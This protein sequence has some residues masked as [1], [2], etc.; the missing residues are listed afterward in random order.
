MDNGTRKRMREMVSGLRQALEAELGSGVWSAAMRLAFAACARA[1]GI[2]GEL[3]EFFGHVEGRLPAAAAAAGSA[4]LAGNGDLLAAPAALGWLHQFWHDGERASITA[5]GRADQYAKIAAGSLATATQVYSEEYMVDFLLANSLG[6]LWLDMYPASRLATKWPL[7]VRGPERSRPYPQHDAGLITV[8][9]PACGAGN[10]LL[11]AFDMLFDIYAEAGERDPGAAC[12]AILTNSLFGLDIDGRAVAV[13]RAALWLQA[14]AKAPGLAAAAG[15]ALVKNIVAVNGGQAAREMGSLLAAREVSG[16]AAGLLARRYAVVATNPPYLDKRDYSPEARGYLRRH[17]PAGAGNVYAAFILRCLGM[18]D[19]FVGMVTPQTF[20]FIRS[21]A[22]LRGEIFRR[23]GI[24][25]LAHL[26]LGAFSGPVVD[27]A[28]FV[29]DRKAE[30]RDGPGVYFKLLDEQL[31]E[32]ALRFAVA[33]HN[34]GA[35]GPGV[36]IRTTGQATALPGRPVAYWLGDGLR[37]VLEGSRPL[38]D[39]ADVVLGMK[40]SDNRRFVRYWWEVAGDD[41]QPLPGWAPYEKEASGYRYGRLPAHC[42]RW[43]EAAQSH[44][45][46]H[47]SAQLPNRRYWF[48]DGIVYGL[49]SS[50]AF[51]AKLLPA[52]HMTDMAAS[53][54]YPLDSRDTPFILG[55][56][57]AKVYQWLLKVF[58]PTVNYQPGDL[59]RLPVPDMS[60]TDRAE[61]GRLALVATDA[62]FY[63]R[64]QKVTDRGF[65]LEPAAWLPLGLGVRHRLIRLWQASLRQVLAA[66]AIDARLAAVMDLPPEERRAV[67]D[68]LGAPLSELP[69][70]AGYDLLPGNDL[71]T[72]GRRVR[73]AP[74]ET[75]EVRKRL[76]GLFEAGPAAGESIEECF[77]RI[78]AIMRLHPVTIY[79]LLS[80]GISAWGWRCRKLDRELTE[81]LLSAVV[82]AV[83]GHTWPQRAATTAP[84]LVPL[85]R[86]TGEPAAGEFVRNFF[87]RFGDVGE[88]EK[89]V[90]VLTGLGIDEWLLQ[91]FFR[92]HVAQFRRRPVVWQVSSSTG[93]GVPAFACLVHCRRAGDISRVCACVAE[94]LSAA[95]GPGC[96]EE[97][98]AFNDRLA[99]LNYRPKPDYGVRMNVAPLQ[100]A[101]LLACPVLTPD[102]LARALADARAWHGRDFLP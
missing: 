34:A 35:G 74:A 67:A 50:K 66:D 10:F 5:R 73:L 26:G 88:L 79:N 83:L 45:R 65:R 58:N 68:G 3:P 86:G 20:L 44:Y 89:D 84:G 77:A 92:R 60:A 57:N 18:A 1:R 23:A 94:R 80:E 63:L 97:L 99:R 100:A 82:L 46:S 47:Y 51:T 4:L 29:L 11:A 8:C 39:S 17:Y 7:H 33:S 52:G 98:A 13:A 21:Y 62:N 75:A 53:G 48:R 12:V 61:I 78:T 31:K 9:D 30:L 64:A 96:R 27:A 2:A 59:L 101:G 6:A 76:Q 24:R 25:T 40:T 93:R 71:P 85:T 70:V 102:E 28:L 87:R 14:A 43:T 16:P 15:E 42:V 69:A 32:E 95:A 56:L 36:F 90:A 37:K 49:I 54:V 55:L 41:G 91:K 19:R 81:E 22:R 38:S 72:P